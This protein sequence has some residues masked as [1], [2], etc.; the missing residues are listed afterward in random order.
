MSKELK[1]E[2]GDRSWN[3]QTETEY[4]RQKEGTVGFFKSNIHKIKRK[5]KHKKK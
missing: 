1:S 2:E 4:K 5:K 3:C